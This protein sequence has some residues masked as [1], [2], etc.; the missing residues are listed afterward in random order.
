MP[1]LKSRLRR[2]AERA[3]S[4]TVAKLQKMNKSQLLTA[5]KMLAVDYR[6][7]TGE[8]RAALGKLILY[9]EGVMEKKNNA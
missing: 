9:I 3:P 5:A 2:A 6:A 8:K 1:K 7:A 4:Y